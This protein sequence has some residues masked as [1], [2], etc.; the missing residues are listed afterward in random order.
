[1]RT[2]RWR[3][4][5]LPIAAGASLL[6]HGVMMT[7]PGWRL[8]DETRVLPPLDARLLPPRPEAQRADSPRAADPAKVVTPH[9][10]A[11]PRHPAAAPRPVRRPLPRPVVESRPAPSA[12]PAEAPLATPP[13]ELPAPAMPPAVPPA[14]EPSAPPFGAGWASSGKIQYDVIRG[15]RNFIIGRTTHQWSHDQDHYRMETVI[16]TVGLV[17]LIKP[18]R[19]VQRS[20][21]ELLPNGLRPTRFTVERDGQLKEEADF[22]WSAGHVTLITPERR[23]EV[24]LAA[25]DQDLLTL[26]HQLALQRERVEDTE[27]LVVTGKSAVRSLIRNLGIEA[28][29]VP[30]GQ[31]SAY[32]L[33]SSG[34]GGELKIDIWLARD[35]ANLPV[36]LKITDKE[37]D[38]L[39]QVA[40][41]VDLAPPQSA[42]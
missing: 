12:A 40:T 30:A 6:L 11:Q 28:L 42:P 8:P 1:M 37:G 7:A 22:D 18:F 5:T 32:H 39:D 26:M 25:G 16:E 33:G 41:G 36:R 9:P 31:V 3:R 13:A 15:E 17:G 35:Y 10:P 2:W 4:W 24:P 23:R 21:G 20:V 34:H 29:E 27:L 19:M 38:V 14:A